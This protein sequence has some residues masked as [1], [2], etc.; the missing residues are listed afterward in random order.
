MVALGAKLVEQAEVQRTATEASME[1][2]SE[3]SILANVAKNVSAAYEWA[4]T[5]CAEFVGASGKIVFQLN[6]DFDISAMSATERA[7]VVK[8]WQ[9]GAVTFEE[10]R[11]VQRKAGIAIVDD[12]KAK[13][14]IAQDSAS[15]MGIVD[16]SEGEA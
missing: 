1:K 9:A 16:E 12:K 10:M 8:D 2:A 5:T 15:A 11:T 6:T 14:Q 13:E 3:N 7:Q 4:L